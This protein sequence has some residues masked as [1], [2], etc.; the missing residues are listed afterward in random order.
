M[1]NAPEGRIKGKNPCIFRGNKMKKERHSSV[2]V[3]LNVLFTSAL[4]ISNILA[5]KQIELASWLHAT[6]GYIIFP[7]TYILSDIFSEVYGYKA[8]RRMSWVSFGM[9][10][11]M[12]T[13]FQVAI[14]LPYPVWWNNQDA[15]AVVL[16]STPRILIASMAAF[17][18][19]D[20]FN[21]I[22]FQKLRVEHGE[23]GFW[24]RAVTS[25]IVGETIDSSIFFSIAF[26]GKMPLSALPTTVLTGV[27]S[28]VFYEI[29]LM[30]FTLFI[31]RKLQDYEGADIYQQV[32]SF[33]IFG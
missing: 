1:N 28:K 13:A 33:G 23:K 29:F 25:S 32:K 11:F 21:D 4:L 5:T 31:V 30:P 19:G 7:I 2:F 12:V 10:L 14:L 18:I 17:Q 8:S 20:W 16:G 3:F 24:F 15:M 27:I 9:N 6:G 22:V 26:I